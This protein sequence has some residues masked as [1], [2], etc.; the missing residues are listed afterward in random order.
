M[1]II[2]IGSGLAGITFAE[3]YRTLKPDDSI[4]VLTREDH[5]F[6]SRPMLSHGFS[7]DDIEQAI[8]MKP[9]SQL[10]EKGIQIISDVDVNE[11]DRDNQTVIFDNTETLAF[12]KLIL[13]QGSAAMVP[14]PFIP[15]QE[16]FF[17]LNSLSDLKQ[18][19]KFRL[20]L[21]N[22]ERAP[23][24][25]VIGG[26]LIGCEVASD[27]AKAGDAVTLYHAMDRLMERQLQPEDSATLLDVMQNARID[28]LMQQQVQGFQSQN[29]K[30]LVN[31]ANAEAK[32]FDAIIVS[33]G[34]KPRTEL[35]AACGLDIGRG[36]KVDQYLRTNDKNIHALGDVAELPN[37]KLYAFIMPIRKQAAWLANY[38][39]G[40]DENAWQAQDFKAKAKVHGFEA[41][42]PY[43]F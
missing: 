3:K 12:D 1:R 42:H 28:I 33:C 15:F 37:G 26:G 4:T 7:R 20:S 29:G 2:I 14:P 27:L 19:R 11:I 24:W 9:F 10:A 13:A 23:E 17:L 5:G 6:Y 40:K 30:M 34:F 21:S 32:A 35:A 31:S 43:I 25:A 39:A 16:H 18:L 38:L 41:A 36:I 8:I 22:H